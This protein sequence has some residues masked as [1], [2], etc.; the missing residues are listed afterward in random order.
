MGNEMHRHRSVKQRLVSQG[1]SIVGSARAKQGITGRGQSKVLHSGGI[2]SWSVGKA[3]RRAE[4][5]WQRG[6]QLGRSSVKCYMATAIARFGIG[7]V[8][9]DL[10]R[11]CNV[12]FSVGKAGRNY[13]LLWNSIVNTA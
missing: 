1:Y 3:L 11:E 8:Q 5:Q 9:V 6:V 12:L 13:D 4:V 10:R 7:I 2:E